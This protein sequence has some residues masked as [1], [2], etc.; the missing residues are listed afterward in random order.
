MKGLDREKTFEQLKYETESGTFWSARD[1]MKL[2]GYTNWI[3]FKNAIGRAVVSA[4]NIGETVEKHFLLAP[5]KKNQR[6]RPREDFILSRYACYL[7]AQN[8]DPRIEEIAWAQSY[9]AVQT[10]RQE[11]GDERQAAIDRVSAR[12]KLAF[13]EREFAA[14]IHKRDVDGKGI[15][16]IRARGDKVLFGGR[17]TNDMKRRYDVPLNKP[18][19]D[20]L[21]TISIKAKDLAAEITTFNT[22]KKDLRGTE[23]I[24]TEHEQNNRQVRGVLTRRGIKPELL[25]PEDDVKKLERRIKREDKQ[26]PSGSQRVNYGR[27]TRCRHEEDD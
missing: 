22:Q 10:R 1:I 19:A 12:H 17:T 23:P 3:N 25:K 7:I 13:T 26:L 18:L 11:V 15:G 16:I 21:P 8:G 2:L 14:E 27:D 24:A 4:K 9:F 5:A 6:G 20:Y